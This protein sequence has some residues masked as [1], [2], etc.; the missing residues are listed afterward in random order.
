MYK[1]SVSF[2]APPVA[3]VGFV[4]HMFAIKC[5]HSCFWI[6]KK[7]LAAKG[8]PCVTHALKHIVITF[9]WRRSTCSITVTFNT[10]LESG[11][12]VSL[13]LGCCCSMTHSHKVRLRSMR[14]DVRQ[15][16]TAP[17]ER[18]IQTVLK[19]NLF[20]PSHPSRSILFVFLCERVQVPLM[21]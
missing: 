16:T 18:K 2:T 12:S 11:A 13:Y 15:W 9:L 17:A 14:V 6:K 7:K 4:R 3:A 19:H 8:K 5:M 10:D 1:G 21:E 20:Y